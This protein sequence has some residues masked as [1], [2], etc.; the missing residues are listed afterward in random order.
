MIQVVDS[1][2]ILYAFASLRNCE[3]QNK[4]RTI[5]EPSPLKFAASSKTL[6][7]FLCLILKKDVLEICCEYEHHRLIYLML[8]V[9]NTPAQLLV[10]HLQFYVAINNC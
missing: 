4:S 9:A 6:V 3:P 8:D 10:P 5:S 7:K 1:T 2:S